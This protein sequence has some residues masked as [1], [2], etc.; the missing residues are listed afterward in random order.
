MSSS[1]RYVCLVVLPIPLQVHLVQ[2]LEGGSY[3]WTNDMEG[4]LS[5]YA[6]DL[7]WLGPRHVAQQPT[8][9]YRKRVHI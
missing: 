9:L 1:A 4:L 3:L 2:C 8:R 6:G 7:Q 5:V